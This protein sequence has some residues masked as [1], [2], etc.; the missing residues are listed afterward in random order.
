MSNLLKQVAKPHDNPTT[1]IYALVDPRT[2]CV[3][4]VGKSDEPK[5]RYTAHLSPR[6]LRPKSHKVHW[7]KEL[8]ADGLKPQLI[9]L[10]R[11]EQPQW[12]NAERKWIGYYKNLQEFPL[13]TNGTSGGDGIDKGTKFSQ[14]TRKQMSASHTGRVM[15][16]EVIAKIKA[17]QTGRPLA[18]EHCT[19]LSE[20]QKSI[21]NNFSDV[22]KQKR[23]VNLTAEW[24]EERK[25]R[26]SIYT[27]RKRKKNASGFIG[28]S[29]R[30]KNRWRAMTTLKGKS[31][32]LGYFS[33]DIE[34]AR[35]YD[36]FVLEHIGEGT[37]LNFPRSHYE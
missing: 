6:Q 21:W 16:P 4:Y 30:T 33:S 7:I 27:R 2:D 26:A 18:K 12:E 3:R 31:V 9:L 14:Q 25:Q 10:E 17:T 20:A 28:V 1:F 23:L 32:Y 29:Q 19:K 5:R 15:P 36:R 24:T 22:E 34:A 8:L 37:M 13:L 11:V 35:A